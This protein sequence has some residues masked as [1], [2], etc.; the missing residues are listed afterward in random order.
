MLGI[1]NEVSE[2]SFVLDDVAKL[3]GF[4]AR[5]RSVAPQL[6]AVSWAQLE[7]FTQAILDISNGTVALW[8]LIMFILVALGL[9]NTLLMAVFERT[10]EFGLVQA[11]GL[12][13][14]SLLLQVL[15]ESAFLVGLGVLAGVISALATLLA[16]RGGL[17]LSA[18]AQGGALFGI[19]RRL[20]PHINVHVT[21]LIAAFVWVMGVVTS[22]YPAWR[23]GRDAPV[24][25]ISK[26]Y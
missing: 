13:P 20:Y 11:L 16:F 22:L 9:V 4:L 2:I 23:A 24:A 14:T 10:R 7:P 12:R 18:L 15:L 19:G 21:V 8:T 3:P 6:Q 25:T 26:A 17:D 1:G 5:I